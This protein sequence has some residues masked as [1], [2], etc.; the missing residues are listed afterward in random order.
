MEDGITV[1]EQ[2]QTWAEPNFITKK[3]YHEKRKA[4]VSEQQR[5]ARL[6]CCKSCRENRKSSVSEE[7]RAGRLVE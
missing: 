5:A 7:Q 4:T 6:D 2:S 1:V 3:T